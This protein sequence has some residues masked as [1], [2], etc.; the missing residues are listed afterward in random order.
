MVSE[1]ECSNVINNALTEIHNLQKTRNNLE[2]RLAA[3]TTA[4]NKCLELAKNTGLSSDIRRNNLVLHNKY[5]GHI[6]GY[7]INIDKISKLLTTFANTPQVIN[8]QEQIE[9]E[10]GLKEL[11]NEAN[12]EGQTDGGRVKKYSQYRKRHPRKRTQKYKQYMK[13]LFK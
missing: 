9:L 4:A 10:E 6:R 8:D 5:L 11:L 12:V 2:L 1:L 7:K 13:R 3:S